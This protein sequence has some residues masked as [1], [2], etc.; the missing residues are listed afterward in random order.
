MRTSLRSFA[1]VGLG[2]LIASCAGDGPVGP[3]V[4]RLPFQPAALTL[5]SVRFAEIHYD[6]AGTDAGEAIEV[7]APAGTDLTGWQVVLYNGS[8]TSRSTYDTKTLSGIVPA[9]CGARGVVV[10]AYP[11]NGIQNGDPD[12]IALVDA[13]GAVVEFLSYGGTFAAANGPAAGLT[14]VDIGIK[15]SGTT[16]IGH[17]LQR[18][19]AGT[20]TAAANTFGACNDD[21]GTPPPAV[22][23]SV[24][25]APSSATVIEGS[26]ATFT[27][28]AFDAAG[29]PL[30][31]VTF[32]W[33]SDHPLVATVSANGVATGVA[34]GDAQI[35]ATAPN[36]VSGS[37]A[38][39]VDAQP[40]TGIPPVHFSE[41]HYDNFGTDANEAIEV[42]APAGTDL[43]GWTI[44]LYNGTGG[45]PY[46]TSPLSGVIA[47]T[48]GAAQATG[49]TSVAYPSNGIQ[50]GSPDGMA[51]VDASGAVVEFLSYEGTFVAAGGPA[52]GMTSVDIVASQNSSPVGQTLQRDA[53]NTW[54]LAN[55]TLGACNDGS[56]PPPPTFAFQFSGRD[57]VADPPLPVGYQDQVFVSVKDGSG[58]TLTLPVTW[59]SESPSIMTVDAN[60]VITALSVGTATLRAT[61]SN[62]ATATYNLPT[63][64]A[65]AGSANYAGNAEF[66]E[67]ADADASD[68]FIVRRAEFTSSFSNVRNTP[69]WVSYEIDATHF[70]AEDRCD[71]FTY[72]PQLPASFARYNTNDYTGSGAIAGYG[73]DRGHLA[74]SFDRTSGSLDNA[75]SFLF[76]NIVPQAA[77]LNQGPWANM[78][79]YLGDLARFQNREVYIV[80]G[81]AGNKGTLKNE[82]LITIP[83][84]TWKVALVLP[85]DHGLAD[86]HG[87][88]DIVE[89]VAV[90]MPNIPGIRNVNWQTYKTTVDAVELLSGYDLLALLDDQVEIALESGTRPPV[91]ALNGP[92]TGAEGSSVAMSAAGSSDPD[93]D[94][95]TFAWTFGDGA[96]ASGASVSHTY[97]QN[98]VYTVSVTATDP[99]GLT[100]SA[101]STVTVSNVAPVIAP[102]TGATILPGETYTAS[103]S[104]TD[105]GADTWTATADY[106][107]GSGSAALGLSG[108]S[109]G[110]SHTYAA[111][112]SFTVTVTVGDG[113][114][115]SS[116]TA[117]VTVLSLTQGLDIARAAVLQL[118]AN[119]TIN[120][121]NAN[122]LR[123]KIDAAAASF[124]RGNS[125]S[126][127]NQLRALLNEL[128]AMVGSNRLTSAEAA[129]VRGIVE[130]VIEAAE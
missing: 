21:T 48:C 12:A 7:S 115:Q 99:R 73:I 62:G 24:T 91:A 53:F 55:S 30:G 100:S 2:V 71:C 40:V 15:E 125:T 67:P 63:R 98:G 87:L 65:V 128:D 90:I 43:T 42:E 58:T 54:T 46:L 94:A 45:A 120:N 29:Q 35:T 11:S 106:G 64:D 93:G 86:V 81:V 85:R 130:R 32:T 80:A 79:N 124:D 49:I 105:P 22:V 69:N 113:D 92:W 44:V 18:D 109:F 127:L 116:A 96:V 101:T 110:L 16:P 122:S 95:L 114:A 104:F 9:T 103:G 39:H 41:L 8:A 59:T 76:T 119:G 66:G 111:A 77:D 117:T 121:G 108:M 34:A 31:G 36:G 6:N 84:Y 51:L 83:D 33:S 26:T 14:P 60:G 126:A 88:G 1:L 56:T 129:T 107:D 23:A 13:G 75:H 97:A 4:T 74:R 27:A 61:L 112:G 89:V 82:G 20:W 3:R 52:N 57:P 38:L 17:S 68:D 10:Q 78:E 118:A 50:N 102:F 47:G 5:P 28:S 72:D 19:G 25:V 70:G 123:A 37:A